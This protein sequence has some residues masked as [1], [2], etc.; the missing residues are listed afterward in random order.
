MLDDIP[1]AVLADVG[2]WGLVTLGVLLVMTGRLVPRSTVERERELLERR[3]EDWRAAHEL[4][5]A[6]RE[7]QQRQLDGILDA[8]RAIGPVRAP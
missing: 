6:A 1:L 8:V 2:P 7:V 3:A 5:E 4:T